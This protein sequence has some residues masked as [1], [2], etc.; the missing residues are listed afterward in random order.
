MYRSAPIRLILARPRLFAA[1][2]IALIVGVAMPGSYLWHTRAL[3]GWD[4]GVAFFLLATLRM[5]RRATRDTIRRRARQHDEGKS[6]VLIVAI[7]SALTSLLAIGFEI[8]GAKDLGPE[9][10]ALHVGLAV[11]TI[12]LSWAFV[13]M[14]FALHYAHEHFAETAD[15][16]EI[17]G[18]LVFPGP[19]EPV[20]GDFLYFAY[21]IGMTGQTSDVAVASSELRRLALV[22]GVIAFFFNTVILA[23]TI[24]IAAGLI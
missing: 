21:V 7:V 1:A 23:L 4:V 18:G 17:Q 15:G 16:A 3:V 13:H 2:L 20:Y 14:V 11:V 12:V 10:Q 5:A 6:A 9:R 24:N 8:H 22:Q 19:G